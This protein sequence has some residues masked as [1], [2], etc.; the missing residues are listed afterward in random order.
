MS[1]VTNVGSSTPGKI[2][3]WSTD[4]QYIAFKYLSNNIP[5]YDKYHFR[6]HYSSKTIGRYFV[7]LTFQHKLVFRA[8]MF[9]KLISCI[10]LLWLLASILMTIVKAYIPVAVWGYV[11]MPD[12][13]P[14]A[15][16][17]VFI[18]GDGVSASTSTG[19][20]GKYGPVTLTVSKTPVTITVRAS[21]DGYS[22]SASKTGEGVIRIDVKL[23]APSPSPT[24]TPPPAPE[25]K[26]TRLKI[27]ASKG[28]YV[29]ESVVLTGSIYPAM[30]VEIIIVV[31]K[32]DGSTFQ[33][34]VNSDSQGRFYYEFVPN[35]L[36]LYRVYARF[37]GNKD[38]ESSMS[39]IISFYVKMKPMVDLY[40]LTPGPGQIRIGGS[41]M[42]VPET[43]STIVL[44]ISLDGGSSWLYLCN[45]T[46]DFKGYFIIDMN[47]SIGGELSFKAIF[48]G[49][50]KLTRAETTKSLIL[51]LMSEE[52]EDLDN[53]LR[54]LEEENK[55]LR[56]NIT[57]LSNSLNEALTNLK[58]LEEAVLYH[59]TEAEKYEREANQ[60]KMMVI[61]ASLFSMVGLITGVLLGRRFHGKKG[62]LDKP[63]T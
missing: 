55:Q 26:P 31:T 20:D 37:A 25:K 50:E 1:L 4:V 24:H 42:P 56:A 58:E 34:K 9:R 3:P 51:R 10:I 29:N 2:A 61:G 12:G 54:K 13:S 18:S 30:S 60:Y 48:T 52:E 11:Y 21:K 23:S 39:D 5:S 6:P 47:I 40:I 62:V 44:H 19:S 49:T 17:S 41:V 32:P 28:E 38:Y 7:Y 53:E 8:W 46:T 57:N 63:A 45:T 59:K 27:E 15:G 22:G 14:A 33:A 16:A 35:V 36:G 43:K